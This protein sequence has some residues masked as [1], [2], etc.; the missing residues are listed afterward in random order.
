MNFHTFFSVFYSFSFTGRFNLCVKW[1]PLLDIFAFFSV[2]CTENFSQNYSHL[3]A[4]RLATSGLTDF[5]AASISVFLAKYQSL[6]SWTVVGASV[7]YSILAFGW[8][9]KDSLPAASWLLAFSIYMDVG[10]NQQLPA[11]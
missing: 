10:L 6:P 1:Q 2:N 11:T 3:L 9:E 8:E 5:V 7:P 4:N